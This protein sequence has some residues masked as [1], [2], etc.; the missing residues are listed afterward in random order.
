MCLD[1]ELN[2]INYLFTVK[3]SNIKL[4]CIFVF[5]LW[6]VSVPSQSVK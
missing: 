4:Y 5:M 2:A 3:N 6:Y 1:H